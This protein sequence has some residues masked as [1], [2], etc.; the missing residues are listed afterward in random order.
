MQSCPH[1]ASQMANGLTICKQCGKYRT[2]PVA[3]VLPTSAEMMKFCQYCGEKI[4]AIDLV[5]PH[6]QRALPAMPTSTPGD[7]SHSSA[8]A[9]TVEQATGLPGTGSAQSP[10]PASASATPKKKKW[11]FLK[12]ALL[13][14]G[15]FLCVCVALG[16]M[17]NS[18]GTSQ[19]TS[20]EERTAVVEARAND[21]TPTTE[22]A[23]QTA[24][25]TAITIV[26]ES[27]ATAVQ[28]EIATAEPT[29]EPTTTATIAP[30][31]APTEVPTEVPAATTAPIRRDLDVSRDRVE[32][33]Y[34]GLGTKFNAETA[35]ADGT[36]RILG[37]LRA[38]TIVELQGPSN[39][40]FK[41]SVISFMTPAVLLDDNEKAAIATA[42]VVLPR[43]C[44]QD[45][46]GSD[47]WVI[48]AVQRASQARS[49]GKDYE[50]KKTFNDGSW[51]SLSAIDGSGLG[52]AGTTMMTFIIGRD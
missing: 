3:S 37:Q 22:R 30:T 40:L 31:E 35:L 46:K 27:A 8:F 7:A 38:A 15:V 11:S 42:F 34:V 52:G 14:L 17:I 19:T 9:P 10:L 2:D 51:I 18:D 43:L 21:R 39:R 25:A 26:T 44:L 28:T 16:S 32:Q 5:C 48:N 24:Q 47:E 41:G 33:A 20:R 1:C 29:E 6:C 23:T 4:P 36:P 12:I 50:E 49:K 13:G 45:W